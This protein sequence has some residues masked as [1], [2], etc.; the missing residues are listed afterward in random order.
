MNQ[1]LDIPPIPIYPPFMPSP[2]PPRILKLR[3]K[4]YHL[5]FTSIT[6][7]PGRSQAL[8][9][10]GRRVEVKI[11]HPSSSGRWNVNIHR[12]GVVDESA[13]H[14]YI[15]ILTDVP[16]N[17]SQ[18]LYLVFPAPVEVSGFKFTFSSLTRIHA[19][20]IDAWERLRVG[21]EEG[22]GGLRGF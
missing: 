15:F 11:S 9:V 16:G 6:R 10:D 18:P 19:G 8:I 5:G 13:A 12:R 14:A 3:D 20:R 7:A 21:R 4:L 1:S 22:E 2:L 17:G